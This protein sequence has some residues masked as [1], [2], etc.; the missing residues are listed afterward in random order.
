MVAA[1]CRQFPRQCWSTRDKPTH[2]PG[3]EAKL[4]LHLMPSRRNVELG[5]RGAAPGG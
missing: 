1:W 3:I 5:L 2:S 4:A